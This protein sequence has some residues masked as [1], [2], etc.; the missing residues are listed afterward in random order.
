MSERI[1]V[2]LIGLP[3][4][5]KSTYR[6]ETA[7]D[8]VIISSDDIIEKYAALYGMTYSEAFKKFAPIANTE[9]NVAALEAFR[10]GKSVMWDQTNLTRNKRQR[11]LN[12]APSDYKKIAV[13][14]TTTEE[15]RLYRNTQRPGKVIPENVLASMQKSFEPVDKGEGFDTTCE[16]ET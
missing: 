2:V 1:L 5:G 10:A 3:C 14:F 12:M 8:S 9:M 6:N 11:I 13:T 16:I 7:G 4:S 15:K